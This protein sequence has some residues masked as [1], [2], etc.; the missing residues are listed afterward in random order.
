MLRIS[1]ETAGEIQARGAELVR[2]S[3]DA[4]AVQRTTPHAAGRPLVAAA[5]LA[6][7]SSALTS[8]QSQGRTHA[9]VAVP[10]VRRYGGQRR[11]FR[12]ER[13]CTWGKNQRKELPSESAGCT[14]GKI[15]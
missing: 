3:V 8:A 13:L 1:A 7:P 11:A 6:P 9:T 15:G 12:P 4:G 5:V 14:I 10:L 2:A